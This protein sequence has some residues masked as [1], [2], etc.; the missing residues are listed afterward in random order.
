MEKLIL[1]DVSF[2]FFDMILMNPILLIVALLIGGFLIYKGVTAIQRE[3]EKKKGE[4]SEE[5]QP[6]GTSPSESEDP[7]QAPETHEE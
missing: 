7:A 5:E 4:A 3:L 1:L 6:G 2:G